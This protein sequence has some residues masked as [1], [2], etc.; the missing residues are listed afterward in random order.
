MMG[1]GQ[2]SGASGVCRWEGS[3]LGGMLSSVWSWEG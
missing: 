3:L 2:K 1:E